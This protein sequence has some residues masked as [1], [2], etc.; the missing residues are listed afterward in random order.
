MEDLPSHIEQQK[1]ILEKLNSQI[2]DAKTNLSAVLQNNEVTPRDLENYKNDKP[3]ID[4]LVETQEE[5]ADMSKGLDALREQLT[6]ERN[7]R[8]TKEHE[9]LVPEHELDEANKILVGQE[10]S[11]PI[12]YNELYRLTNNLFRQPSKYV[13]VI[14]YLRDRNLKLRKEFH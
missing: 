10:S 8:I 9:W 11:A 6:E 13:D 14:K 12:R 4:T 5:M 3:V 1:E 2:K 7:Q